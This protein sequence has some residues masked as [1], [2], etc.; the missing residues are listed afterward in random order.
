M[1]HDSEECGKLQLADLGE[2]RMS[3]LIDSDSGSIYNELYFHFPK[4]KNGSGFE[5]L[6][7]ADHGSK[8]LQ[9]LAAPTS[10]YTVPYLRAVVHGTKIYL[11]PLQRNLDSDLCSD[12]VSYSICIHY[13]I[14]Q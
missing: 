7:V 1:A 8:S 14:A 13:K 4:L 12:E 2:K 11:R 6:R 5:M 9:V 10:G 3:I